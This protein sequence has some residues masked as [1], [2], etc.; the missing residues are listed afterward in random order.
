[1]L[2]GEERWRDLA[3]VGVLSAA[4][5]L[6][7]TVSMSEVDLVLAVLGGLVI[8]EV[9]GAASAVAI[10]RNNTRIDRWPDGVG[11]ALRVGAV[12]S[13]ALMMTIVLSSVSFGRFLGSDVEL[14]NESASVA[15]L[16]FV[17]A[18]TVAFV[19]F[20]AMARLPVGSVALRRQFH[21]GLLYRGGNGLGSWS[22]DHRLPRLV[23]LARRCR[24]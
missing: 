17:L 12:A 14:F 13:A 10:A 18:F 20:P 19:F 24:C 6:I 11:R 15:R 22:L 8:G 2:L 4:S 7:V 23:P 9:I 21:N 5:R 3:L 1:M 16:V